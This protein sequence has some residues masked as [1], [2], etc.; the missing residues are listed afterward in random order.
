LV[1]G[2]YFKEV[3]T[4]AQKTSAGKT[5]REPAQDVKIYHEADV[6]VV[7]GGPGGVG[8]AIS[9]A[10]TG[11]KTILV[12]RYGHLGGMATGGQVLMVPQVFAGIEPYKLVGVCQEWVDR[13]EPL[14]GCLHPKKE[15]IGSTDP[16]VIKNWAMKTF[17]MMGERMRFS[18]YFDQEMLKCVCND[19]VEEAG[20]KILLHSWA[21]RAIVEK[22]KVKGVIFDSKSGRMAVMGKVII[23]TTGDGDLFQ[24]AGAAFDDSKGDGSLRSSCLALVFRVGNV[25][26]V[27]WSKFRM[28]QP[29]K[30]QKVKEKLDK[31]YSEDI[32]EALKPGQMNPYHLVPQATPRPDVIWV[33]NWIL[34]RSSMNVDDLTWVEINMRKAMRAW[35][36]FARANMP[37]YEN[38][39]IVDTASQQGTRGGRRL[40]GEY[41]ITKED[42][43]SP[44]VHEDTVVMFGRMAAPGKQPTAACFPYRALVPKE[45]EGFLTAGRSFSSDPFANNMANLIP[46]CVATGQAAGTAAALAVKAKVEPRN[47]DYKALQKALKAQGFPMPK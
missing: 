36:K 22:N 5:Y 21:S 32:L 3:L 29:E 1:S 12:E 40:T 18:V 34:N 2:Q 43:M 16:A 47:V 41:V 13:C 33:N 23:D 25:D 31:I 37:G 39:W 38:A 35:L 4:V 44:Q 26:P 11:A 8:A 20:A 45:V 27:K 19:L 42:L 30:H 6:V 15:D 24:S 46:H 10:R 7:G 9:A 14:D 28:E 17:G